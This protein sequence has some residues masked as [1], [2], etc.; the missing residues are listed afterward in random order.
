MKTGMQI[1]TQFLIGLIFG[2]GLVISGMSNPA[3]VLNFLDLAAIPAGL[4]DASL[5]FVMGG[6]VLVTL[7]GYRLVFRRNRPIW[8]TQFHLP[9]LSHI[10]ARIIIGPAI[11][12]LGWGMAGFC[13]G[14][15]FTAVWTGQREALLFIAAMLVGMMGARWL[16]LWPDLP[17]KPKAAP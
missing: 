10:D 3:K 15:A 16:A 4:W 13:P 1:A 5:G 11:F 12:G 9:A 2:I 17:A 7:V 8:A 6:A 14:P